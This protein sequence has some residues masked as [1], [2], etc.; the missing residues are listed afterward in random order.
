MPLTWGFLLCWLKNKY[1]SAYRYRLHHGATCLR[2][3]NEVYSTSA[4]LF[5]FSYRAK[6]TQNTST[7]ESPGRW[8]KCGNSYETLKSSFINYFNLKVSMILEFTLSLAGFVS[9][10]TTTTIFLTQ[11]FTAMMTTIISIVGFALVLRMVGKTQAIRQWIHE[12]LLI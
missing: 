2:N 3:I 1:S 11:N 6:L 10:L 7:A 9:F 4:I 12:N 5:I 8:Q